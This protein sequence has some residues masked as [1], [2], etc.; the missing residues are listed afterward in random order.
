VHYPGSGIEL[1]PSHKKT[2]TSKRPFDDNQFQL[3]YID[4][5]QLMMGDDKLTIINYTS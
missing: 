2:D 5:D 4:D 1:L 3:T